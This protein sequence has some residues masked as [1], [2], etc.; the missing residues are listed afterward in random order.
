MGPE[1]WTSALRI[2]GS[3][4]RESYKAYRLELGVKLRRPQH[5]RPPSPKRS[6]WVI[7]AVFK[8]QK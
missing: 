5:T 4:A 2:A 8:A 7:E 1:K 6:S 3:R